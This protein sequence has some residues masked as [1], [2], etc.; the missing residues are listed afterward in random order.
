[1]ARHFCTSQQQYYT[2]CGA[3][4]V[5]CCQGT[6]FVA[7]ATGSVLKGRSPGIERPQN[8]LPE[9]LEHDCLLLLFDLL[10]TD[11]KTLLSANAT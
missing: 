9:P 6:I 7:I 11:P 2:T 8:H 10:Q 4:A 1:M 5:R 3:G